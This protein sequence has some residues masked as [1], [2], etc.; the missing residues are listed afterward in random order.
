MNVHAEEWVD[1][2][3]DNAMSPHQRAAAEAHLSGCAAC[4]E[5]VAER[6]ALSTL[7]Q[8]APP[9]VPAKSERQFVGEIELQ[10]ERNPVRPTSRA[11]WA[12]LAI[13]AALIL[14]WSYVQAV[15]LVSLLLGFLPGLGGSPFGGLVQPVQP[16]VGTNAIAWL[17]GLLGA[18]EPFDW[19]ELTSLI[20]LLVVGLLYAGWMSIWWVHHR[21]GPAWNS[22]EKD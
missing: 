21:G 9:V 16:P 6:L 22:S 12:W 1:A 17:L 19:N 15:G 3:I 5:L 2:Y 4:R 18:F 13:P 14:L 10:L 20:G 11:R 7:L 8:E